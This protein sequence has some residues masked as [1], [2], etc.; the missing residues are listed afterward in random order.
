M[1]VYLGSSGKRKLSLNGF[2]HHLNLYSAVPIINNIRLL[3]LDNFVLKDSN[4][5]YLI[6]DE[7]GIS[8]SSIDGYI[9][10]DINEVYITVR[11]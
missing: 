8:L 4:G 5:V 9:L 10:K 3:S 1:A 6:A 7:V 2:K 11:S